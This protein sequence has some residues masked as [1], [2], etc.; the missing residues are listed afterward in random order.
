[1][2]DTTLGQFKITAKLGEG[3]MGAV[4]RAEDTRLG[5]EVAIKVLPELFT[6][7]PERLAR[8]EREA[9]MLAS[10]NHPNIA[11]LHDVGEAPAAAGEAPVHFLVMELAPGVDLTERIARGPLSLEEALPIAIQIAQAIEAAHEKGII[12]RDLKPANVKV[13]EKGAVKVL[14]F[15]LA[16][17][18]APQ[19]VSGSGSVLAHSPTLTAQMTQ[20]GTLLG[21]AAYMS[22]EQARGKEADKRADIWAFGCI[23]VEML[24]GE[25]TFGGETVTDVF[26][27]IITR[28]PPWEQLPA[29]TP[30]PVRR[31]LQRCL[32]KN[33]DRRLHDVAD[34]RI[35]LEEALAAGLPTGPAASAEGAA[36]G[37]LRLWQGIAAAAILATLALGGL[38]LRPTP[39]PTAATRSTILPPEGTTFDLDWRDP[40]VVAVSP[41]GR[42]LAFSAGGE[43]GATRLFVRDLD[44]LEARPRAGTE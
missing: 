25:H 34:A 8:F 44:D 22:P 19:G 29:R 35:E 4:Y 24:T 9:R 12:H 32:E 37:R 27:S 21:T 3:G 1:M 16:K 41:D 28:D 30:A 14:D 26:A 11:S 15:G 17:A 10:L 6:A 42:S 5:R 13:T 40:G 33:P 2:I 31:T 39:G 18:W 36:P 43:D 38:L 23:V 20:A 7:D